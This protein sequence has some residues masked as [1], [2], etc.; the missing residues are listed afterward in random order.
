MMRSLHSLLY[1]ILVAFPLHHVVVTAFLPTFGCRRGCSTTFLESGDGIA[2]DYTWHEEAFELEI[3]INVPKDTRAKDIIFKATSKSIDLRLK[4]NNQSGGDGEED[5]VLLDPSRK[6]RGRVSLEGTF[7]VISDPE[8]STEDHRQVTVTIE[9][10]IRTAKDDF[11]V[12][13]YDWKGVYS[14]EDEEEVSFRK[15]DE[16]EALDIRDYAATLGVDIDNI[17]MSM[18]D[19]TMFSSGLNLTQSSMDQLQQAGLIKEEVTQQ[20][21]GSEWVTDDDGDRVPF[22]SMGKS[23]TKEEM[24]QSE[25][26]ASKIPFLD[27]DS[28]WHKAVPI[29]KASEFAK[30]TEKASTT[31]EKEKDQQREDR[32]E[33][34]RQQ[35]EKSAV[36]PVGALTVTRLKEILRSRGLK[37]SGNKK[38]LQDR[39]REQVNSMLGDSKDKNDETLSS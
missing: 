33:Q 11:D 8:D 39:L 14:E 22:S 1:C 21:D 9:K 29:D 5:V 7:W 17:N 32:K 20:D 2:S 3:T 36:D 26:P 35:R 37:V 31:E 12:I 18:V 30:N 15:Y 23:V 6:L 34:L 38:E 10:Q 25:A 24:Q 19:K 16:P 27:T 28:A 4:N 13:D